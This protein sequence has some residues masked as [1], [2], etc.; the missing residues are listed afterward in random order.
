MRIAHS[1]SVVEGIVSGTIVWEVDPDFGYEVA[2]SIP[3]FDDPELL[4]PRLMYERRGLMDQYQAIVS[5]LTA[6]RREYLRSFPGLDSSI[7]EAI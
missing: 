2:V 6:E 4:R 1:S 7:V 3:G 5:T